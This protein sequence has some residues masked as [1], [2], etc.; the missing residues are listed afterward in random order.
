MVAVREKHGNPAPDTGS[1]LV[2][3]VHAPPAADTRVSTPASVANTIAPARFQVP[4]APRPTSS[5]NVCGGPPEAA[6]VF[7]FLS[8]KK[9]MVRLSGDQNGVRANCVPVSGR[10]SPDS[11]E[12]SHQPALARS[13]PATGRQ[14]RAQRTRVPRSRQRHRQMQARLLD[15]RLADVQTASADRERRRPQHGRDRPRSSASVR[16]RRWLAD[17]SSAVRRCRTRPPAPGARRRCRAR[18]FGSF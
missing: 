3:S 12:R 13:S 7:S 10:I 14:A 15:R 9:A 1:G 11:S 2:S 4:P 17:E 18:C 5:H 16:G 8:A 6:T